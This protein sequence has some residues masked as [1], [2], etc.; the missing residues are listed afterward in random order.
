MPIQ[1]HM[2][3]L[4]R[5]AL[6]CGGFIASLVLFFW[7]GPLF[8][9]VI[10]LQRAADLH[11]IALDQPANPMERLP[12]LRD[13]AAL[14]QA[15]AI[16]APLTPQHPTTLQM[17]G[18][19][20]AATQDW[21]AA[22]DY[23]DA[24]LRQQPV[25]PLRAWQ[26]ALAYEPMAQLLVS[27]PQIDLMPMLSTA[28]I[29]APTPPIST[30]YCAQPPFDSCY[31]ALTEFILPEPRAF[32]AT[33]VSRPTIFMHAPAQLSMPLTVPVTATAL[34]MRIGLHQDARAWPSDGAHFRVWVT[35]DAAAAEL[36]YEYLL[37]PDVA[38]QGWQADW[39]DLSR[40]AGQTVT[41]Q[42]DV[43]GGPRDDTQADWYGWAD[44][45]LTA[46]E[47]AP[48][49][50]LDPTT[51]LRERWEH[52]GFAL[53]QFV[54]QANRALRSG[55][56]EQ[57]LL[58]LARAELL[59]PT[60]A[61]YQQILGQ[62]CQ[63]LD[64]SEPQ[65]AAWLAAANGNWL[66]DVPFVTNSWRTSADSVAIFTAPVICPELGEQLFCAQIE[67]S[68]QGERSSSF[69][70]CLRLEAGATYTFSAWLRV[71]ELPPGARWR[72]LYL[73]GN[74]D[75][76]VRGVGSEFRENP[77]EWRFFER[78]FQALT[79][80]GLT[81]F[82]PLQLFEGGIGWIHAPSLIKLP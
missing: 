62:T 28:T 34:T 8:W 46:V 68:T 5:F 29:T 41:L 35:A 36:A 75:G 49:Q 63:R 56:P 64:T 27:A 31:V 20:A 74:V 79:Y 81:C 78:T 1:S 59:D 57:A 71:D 73:Q 23:F 21:P 9:R 67:I 10:S 53:N 16:L 22:S 80:D 38:A 44:L 65:C 77:T 7:L 40:W 48:A 58:W 30:P 15:S 69:S 82:H 60:D 66:I 26:A 52:G 3:P 42:L 4:L 70:Q 43:S 11:S 17:L 14:A 33:V 37:L 32:P 2:S 55:E 6:I 50:L 24:A 51:R 47:A 76:Q 54:S 18:E 25:S 13:A 61:S 39:V 72:G 12:T 45:R 19:L